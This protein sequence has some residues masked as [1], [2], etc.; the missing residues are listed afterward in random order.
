MNSQSTELLRWVILLPLIGAAI[1]GLFNRSKNALLAGGIASAAI[2]LSFFVAIAT[3]ASRAPDTMSLVD[4]WFTWFK[5]GN[6]EVPFHLEL[7]SFSQVMLL[8]VTGV[9]SLIHIYAIGY[10][11][12]EKSPWRFFAYLN[13]FVSAM[14][15]LVLSSSLVGVF[16]G[17]EGVG[18]CSYLLIGFWYTDDK[19]T[20]A[21]MK[22]FVTNRVGDLG[23]L[24]ALF[25]IIAA[26]GGK[27]QVSDLVLLSKAGT[28]PTAAWLVFAG[29][30]FWASTG[31]SAQFPLY[32]WLPDAMAG[33]TPVSA[34][35]HAATMVTSGIVVITRLWPIFA[36]LHGLLDVMLSVGIGTAYLA[37]LIALTQRDIKKVM[38]Y[39]TVSQL[40][41][42]F[43][44]L[45]A[46]A[47]V[48]AFFHVVTHACFKA[49]LFLGSGSVIHG[50]HEK[51]DMF[52]MGGLR[53]K[54]KITHIT[55]LIATMA[56]IGF[57]LTAGF[58]S[59]DMILSHAWERSPV[60]YVLLLGAAVLTAFYMLRAYTLT[61]WGEAR[62]HE[63][64]HAHESGP[65]MWVPL[66]GTCSSF[67]HRRLV[68]NP[69][70]HLR[71][72]CL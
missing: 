9:G 5:A 72:P 20:A 69:P 40:G 15:V 51:Q 34:L 30:L 13:L 66:S 55:F 25:T 61:F 3:I 48:A 67:A 54:M 27:T 10:M 29:G 39:S 44:A 60:A 36:P 58:F 17:W 62:S 52:E 65:I 2:I 22:A 18:L 64:S 35:I 57:P 71:R 38:A 21:G 6:I 70:R 19:N 7:T 4:H 31:K 46:G 41:F 63:A 37:A 68:R 16:L 23:F 12:H 1:N 8:V 59:K 42:M 26:T 45:G 11:S 53:K 50:M 56:I 47:P 32:V 33:P 24:I 28:I 14:L 49:L 43:A